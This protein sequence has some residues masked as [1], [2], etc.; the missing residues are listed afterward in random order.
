MCPGTVLGMTY[1]INNSYAK[2]SQIVINQQN[3]NWKLGTYKIYAMY[4][5]NSAEFSA[6]WEEHLIRG[7]KF[8]IKDRIKIGFIIRKCESLMIFTTQEMRAIGYSWIYYININVAI[9]IYIY[10]YVC[11]MDREGDD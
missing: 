8:S 11:E 5:I 7:R 2:P 10:L 4:I 6:I 3:K 1:I 9:D